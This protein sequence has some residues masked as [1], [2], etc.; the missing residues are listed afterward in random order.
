MPRRKSSLIRHEP[1]A[2]I[3]KL[4]GGR[5]PVAALVGLHPATVS[6]W[7][8]GG[9]HGF[10]GRIPDQYHDVLLAH[11]KQKGIPINRINFMP[12]AD[13]HGDLGMVRVAE[14]NGS[15]VVVTAPAAS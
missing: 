12:L 5:R 9:K 11:A 3:V 4:L 10:H 1:A 13:Q 14:R 8:M 15:F 6:K 2:T 7:S